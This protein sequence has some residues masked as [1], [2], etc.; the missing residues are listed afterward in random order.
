[1]PSATE[2]TATRLNQVQLHLIE[3][4]SRPMTE[5]ELLDI[6]ELL[7]QYYAQKVDL[8]LDEFWKKKGFTPESFRKSTKNLHLRAKKSANP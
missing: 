6:K 4:F 1:M 8:E 7:V 2:Q 3:L 5:Q